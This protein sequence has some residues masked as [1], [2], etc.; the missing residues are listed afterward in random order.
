M[1]SP[2]QKIDVR[3]EFSKTLTVHKS[4]HQEV[5]LTTADKVRLCLI[6]H[7]DR[8]AAKREWTLPF[9]VLITALAAILTAEFQ[10]FIL[11]GPV[12]KA[13]F[14]LVTIGSAIWFI[15]AAKKAWN[16]RNAGDV[17]GIVQEL[18]AHS[19]DRSEI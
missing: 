1:N 15:V 17:E 3:D 5:I 9:G 19:V 11:D 6:D 16:S 10:K 12:W 18:K 13:I 8:L 7:K 4:L 2:E 14:V